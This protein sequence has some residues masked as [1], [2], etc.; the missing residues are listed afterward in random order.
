MV[1]MGTGRNIVM[2]KFSTENWSSGGKLLSGGRARRP[3]STSGAGSLASKRVSERRQKA[4]PYVLWRDHRLP[5]RLHHQRLLEVVR[6]QLE[7]G[8]FK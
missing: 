1:E 5:L 8:M 6:G 2:F 4:L 3:A 7:R